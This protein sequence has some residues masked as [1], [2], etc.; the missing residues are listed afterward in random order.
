MT[1]SLAGFYFLIELKV[2]EVR[3][4]YINIIHK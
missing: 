4:I 2:N 1:R 3:L